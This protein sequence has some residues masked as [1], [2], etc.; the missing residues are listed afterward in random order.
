MEMKHKD[1]HEGFNVP[2]NATNQLGIEGLEADPLQAH[3]FIFV[4]YY[5]ALLLI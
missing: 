4:L 3:V 5:V 1:L 2:Y